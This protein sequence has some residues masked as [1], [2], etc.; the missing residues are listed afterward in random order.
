MTEQAPHRRRRHG[1]V[2][3]GRPQPGL[4]RDGRRRG[5]RRARRCGHRLSPRC[6]RPMSGFV[7]GDTTSGQQA[8]YAVGLTGI[9][10]VNVNNACATGSTA[11][12]LARQAVASGAVDVALALGFEQMLSGPLSFAVQRPA[13][14]QRHAQRDGRARP[15]LGRQG[16]DRGAILRRRGRRVPAPIRHRH[17]TAVRDD[18]GQVARAMRRATRLPCS[19]SRPRWKRCW[20]RRT[21]FASLTKLQ[22][23]PPTCGAAAAV[24]VSADFA[25]RHGLAGAQHPDRRPG[26]DH[27]RA[28]ELRRPAA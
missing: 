10:I 1:S 13:R 21:I 8:L 28:G 22:C 4:R 12:F 15:G 3:Q 7:I 23:C 11:L 5:A 17:R 9:P 24:V 26:A 2:H 27:R 16:A 25:R 6:S 18:L 14:R 19:A 20:P